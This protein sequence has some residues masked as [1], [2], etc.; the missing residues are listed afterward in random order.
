MDTAPFRDAWPFGGSVLYD[1]AGRIIKR[2]TVRYTAPTLRVNFS[3][4]R[5]SC[6]ADFARLTSAHGFPAVY[7]LLTVHHQPIC[8]C[9]EREDAR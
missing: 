5:P 4:N 1:R 8:T 9:D 7:K 2:V 3:D 6:C